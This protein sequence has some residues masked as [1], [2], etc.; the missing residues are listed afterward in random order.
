MGDP[1][2]RATGEIERCSQTF[3]ALLKNLLNFE[4]YRADGCGEKW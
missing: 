4:Q 3:Y 2:H 1:V